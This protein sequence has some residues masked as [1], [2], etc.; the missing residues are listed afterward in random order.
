MARCAAPARRSEG[1][2][3]LR[4]A[5]PEEGAAWAAA[6]L[7]RPGGQLDRAERIVLFNT[8]SGFN[9]L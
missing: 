2:G 4:F 5:S 3:D 9:Y 7:L 8:G 6:E 1:R